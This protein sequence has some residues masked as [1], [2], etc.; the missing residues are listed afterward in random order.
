M[1]KLINPVPYKFIIYKMASAAL[2]AAFVLLLLGV[3][4]LFAV[5]DFDWTYALLF[6]LIA[7]SFPVF[8]LGKSDYAISIANNAA[9]LYRTK[10]IFN[11]NRSAEF[12]VVEKSSFFLKL[13]RGTI[14]SYIPTYIY[15][16]SDML[17]LEKTMGSSGRE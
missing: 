4:K 7:S 11:T 14:V 12:V 15:D 10:R 6:V 3:G 17:V 5:V 9:M 8:L 1:N 16:K 2:A 13:K